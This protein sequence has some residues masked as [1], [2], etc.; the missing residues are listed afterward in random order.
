MT[1]LRK[2]FQENLFHEVFTGT[3]TVVISTIQ[4]IHHLAPS[5]E[6]TAVCG[7]AKSP[8]TENRQ[9]SQGHRRRNG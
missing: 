3:Q 1:S 5:A 7:G 6:V 4:R 9:E 2:A 8:G